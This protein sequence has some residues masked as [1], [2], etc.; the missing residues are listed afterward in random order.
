MKLKQGDINT[1]VRSNFTSTRC[2][3][4]NQNINILKNKHAPQAEGNF[5]DEHE[6]TD[7]SHGM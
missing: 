7:A 1:K 4:N 5:C 2:G 3:K 6:Q